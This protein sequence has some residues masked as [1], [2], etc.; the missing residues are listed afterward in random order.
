MIPYTIPE[1]DKDLLSCGV[2]LTPE[3]I[4]DTRLYNATR[5]ADGAELIAA[6]RREV[7][8]RM[9]KQSAIGRVNW[10]RYLT[11]NGYAKPPPAHQVEINLRAARERWGEEE[12]ARVVREASR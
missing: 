6:R 3:R 9:G 12:W 2:V 8:A 1:A 11:G 7:Y 4:A 5:G 10:Y